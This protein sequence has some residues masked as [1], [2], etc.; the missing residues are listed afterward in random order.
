MLRNVKVSHCFEAL[1]ACPVLADDKAV[2]S[3]AGESG[4]RMHCILLTHR[5]PRHSLL[6]RQVKLAAEVSHGILLADC[7]SVC[8][9][10][11]EFLPRWQEGQALHAA[12]S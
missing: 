7:S 10:R 8:R 12:S 3:K 11:R 5:Q 4:T 2:P 6:Q 9:Q 1:W